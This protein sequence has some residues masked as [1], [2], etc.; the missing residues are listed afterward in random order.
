[1]IS[2]EALFRIG[3]AA[4]DAGDHHRARRA[5]EQGA[6]LGDIWCLLRLAYMFDIGLGVE[7]DKAFAM[8]C[9]QRAWRRGHSEVAANS[10]ALLYREAGDRRAMFRWFLRAAERGDDGAQVDVAKCYLDGIGVRKSVPEGMKR[11]AAAVAGANIC[12]AE[13]EEAAALLAKFRPRLVVNR[14]SQPTP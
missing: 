13:R 2:T 12:E 6:A 14:S 8:R 10:I 3:D 1:M 5:F 9:Y 7:A 4:Q 11:L